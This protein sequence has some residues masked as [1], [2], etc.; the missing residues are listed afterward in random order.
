VGVA[1]AM[2]LDRVGVWLLAK[3]KKELIL[4][5]AYDRTR[6]IHMREGLLYLKDYPNFYSAL[7]TGRVIVAP[8]AGSD[9]RTKELATQLLQPQVIRSMIV[10][11]VWVRGEIA[12]AIYLESL[13]AQRRWYADEIAFAGAV[14]DQASLMLLNKERIESQSERERLLAQVQEQAH[15][16]RQ[17]MNT[18]PEGLLLL[19]ANGHLMMANPAAEQELPHLL[20][21][22]DADRIEWFGDR[23]LDD[24]LR[25]PENGDWHEV[26]GSDRVFEV[27][28]R[29]IENSHGKQGWVLVLRD[30]TRDREVQ[31]RIQQQERLAAVG[32]LAAGI[33]HDFN[34]IMAV[35]M[36]YTEMM[37][38]TDD[39]PPSVEERLQTVYR[40]SVRAGDLIQQILDF[41]RRSVLERAR[42]DLLPM[43]KEQVK[44][45]ERTLPENIQIKFFY[46]TD[47]YTVKADPTRIQQ[48]VMNL[49]VNA[50][51]AMPEGG[52]LE[53]W[54][55]KVPADKK[56]TC[57]FCGKLEKREWV[58]IDVKDTG[59]GIPEEILPHIF[60]PFFTT[61]EVGKG[62]GLGLSQVYGTVKQH[63]G[64]LDVRAR[65]NV[66]TVFS[67]ILPYLPS[68]SIEPIAE[69]QKKT[70]EGEGE[71]I[72]VVED[73]AATREAL[74]EGLGELG[75]R[76]IQA[77]N[78][79]Q[80]LTTL[81]E[82]PS[83]I[84]LVISDA[85]MPD[86]GGK[87]LLQA[88][89]ERKLKIPVILLTG[90]P[91]MD[92]EFNEPLPEDTYWLQKPA[93]LEKLGA[94]IASVLNR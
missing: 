5:D 8:D 71:L 10:A 54:L 21:E 34:N 87:A 25:E 20:D 30:V 6:S 58:R 22:M 44:M 74:V 70:Y 60:E 52:V 48:A 91:L 50:R 80:A 72:L 12:G 40:Q 84:S 1:D 46:T 16:V 14:A 89:T 73:D 45:L 35:I 78:G 31:D 29:A 94:T 79:R 4:I 55:S 17:I 43:M 90:H 64:H 77:E 88:M 15:Q 61:K 83:K 56:I 81:D 49:A 51:D 18:V 13:D 57:I 85:I 63:D 42:V 62:T 59:E 7:C 3:D 41:S 86:M 47:E 27:A 69:D 36:L 24:L 19:D 66:G 26:H 76:V 2:Q 82:D 53:L 68:P 92:S 32:Q 67:I 38:S 37:L 28:S 75:Y 23:L 93:S 9:Q 65:T 33:A 11:G 39:L